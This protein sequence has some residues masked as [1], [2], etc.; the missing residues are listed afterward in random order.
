[1]P[2][3]LLHLA[4]ILACLL[5][6]AQAQSVFVNELH[7]DDS[8]IDANEGVEIAGP[9][10]TNL[11]TFKLIFYNGATG[12]SYGELPL[13]GTIQAQNG[14]AFGTAFFPRA[15]IQNGS[16]D[17][18]ALIDIVAN[19]VVQ[20]L[21]YEG[22]FRA[23]GG[24]ADGDFSTDIGVAESGS[25]SDGESLQLSGSG[26]VYSDFAWQSASA[27]SPGAINSGQDF[28]GAGM[29]AITLT[30]M[31]T[32]IEEG[33][34]G[35][36]TL[37]LFPNPP[38]PVEVAIDISDR[39]ELAAASNVIV[40][41]SGS[42][43][44]TIT[45]LDDSENDGG[46]DVTL[47]ASAPLYDPAAAT[48]LVL[49]VQRP[50]RPTAIR[51]VTINT[52]N[53]ISPR[54]SSEYQA[55]FTLLDRLEADVIAFQEVS[56]AGDF[57]DLRDLLADLGLPHLAT[58]DDGFDGQAY[59][60]G[61]FNTDQNL[62]IASRYPIMGATQIGR[63]DAGRKE[64]TR[65]PLMVEIDVPEIEDDPVVVAVHYK[66]STDDASRYRRAIEAYRT[67]EVLTA[68]YDASQ[69]HLF[70][71]GDFNEDND[72]FMPVSFRTGTTN[73]SDGSTLPLS[74]QLG[75][76]LAG[77]NSILLP[78]AQFPN[79]L[80]AD[81]GLMTPDH[82]QQDGRARRTFIP[83]GDAALDYILHSQRLA[84]NGTIQTEIYNSSLDRAFDGL[85]KQAEPASPT[86]SFAASDHFAVF[87]DYELA[88]KPKLKLS[89][90]PDSLPENAGPGTATG[91]VTLPQAMATPTS[92]AL[93]A[94]HPDAPISLPVDVLTFA[95][96]ET[97][98]SFDIAIL[99]RRGAAPNRT[100]A[101]TASADGYS[102]ARDTLV[103]YN[104]DPSGQV[105]LSQYIEPPSGTS[106][107]GIE[108]LQL[109]FPGDRSE[110]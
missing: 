42:A 12:M 68:T 55:L 19:S 51:V 99:D 61:Q 63:A 82:R 60:G 13:G 94:I 89:I 18:I 54:R 9:A 34:T 32:I 3:P 50:S 4:I 44:F 66:A 41:V 10:G 20:F 97:Q 73:F 92:I 87:G 69:D 16:P 52:L 85:A 90:T 95:A 84:D 77:A 38:S 6:C 2:K 15:G 58:S 59:L 72:R 74:Y 37:S 71:L 1:M 43:T 109:Q 23:I 27:A 67:L 104:L 31:P 62:A 14:S 28:L 86:T 80:F 103:V 8:G 65:F 106:P 83:F 21:S 70:V 108:L 93:A 53:G 78:Y 102:A 56:S 81:A 91:T 7:Y 30:L 46:Q 88:V 40:P 22:S 29:P 36:A 48:A 26:A 11:S 100:I 76:D 57:F 33:A 101:I 17:G 75:S 98:K 35:T 24:D 47:R 105:L 5:A 110:S 39:S 64:F 107:R 45:A 96:G 79:R 49:D 25:S